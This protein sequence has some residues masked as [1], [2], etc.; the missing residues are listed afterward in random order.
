MFV[1]IRGPSSI[2]RLFTK[3][4]TVWESVLVLQRFE[5][6]PLYIKFLQDLGYKDKDLGYKA[7]DLL[8][9][10]QWDAGFWFGDD[11]YGRVTRTTLIVP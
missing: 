8:I 9:S 5:A 7:K 3:R 4:R 11:L 2:V 1:R 10:F 6:S